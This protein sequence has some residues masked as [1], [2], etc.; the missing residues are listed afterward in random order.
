VAKSKDGDRIRLAGAGDLLS[1]SFRL[2][3]GNHQKINE[4]IATNYETGTL[5]SSI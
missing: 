5:D 3:K 4:K 2:K 1:I